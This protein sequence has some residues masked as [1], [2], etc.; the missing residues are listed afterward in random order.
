MGIFTKLF[1]KQPKYLPLKSLP[2]VGKSILFISDTH[3]HTKKAELDALDA[4]NYNAVIFLGDHY[5]SE[6]VQFLEH[7]SSEIPVYGIL[8]NHDDLNL[9]QTEELERIQ[10][11]GNRVAEISGVKFAFVDG[12]LKY[13]NSP[14]CCMYT[15]KEYE[16]IIQSL[17]E[18]DVLVS[19]APAWQSKEDD[20]Y[21]VENDVIQTTNA[22]TPVK[23]LT[24]YIEKYGVP[25]HIYGHL[26]RAEEKTLRNGT[27]AFCVYRHLLCSF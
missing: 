15:I 18:A 2:G 25:L 8:G 10:Y 19:H 12:S 26:H 7:V 27:K 3:G 6:L 4:K 5:G 1:K 17:P 11:V 9:Y 22:H 13:K 21:I 16:E 23:P 14:G 20:E 24:E